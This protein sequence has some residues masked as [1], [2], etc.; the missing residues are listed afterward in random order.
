MTQLLR[1]AGVGHLCGVRH[2]AQRVLGGKSPLVAPTLVAVL[3][4]HKLV[5]L[6]VDKIDRVDEVTPKSWTG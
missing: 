3:A 6:V 4:V 5:A 2:T 1:C